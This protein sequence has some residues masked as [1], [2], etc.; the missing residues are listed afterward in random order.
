[1]KFILIVLSILCSSPFTFA[2]EK[3]PQANA[4]FRALMERADQTMVYKGAEMYLNLT[5]ALALE[6]FEVEGKQ[7]IR[8]FNNCKETEVENHLTCNLAVYYREITGGYGSRSRNAVFTYTVVVS[9]N[10]VEVVSHV[11]MAIYN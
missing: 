11:N 3:H 2:T 8:F 1:M 5:K 9:G 4:A 10:R 7:D 6:V